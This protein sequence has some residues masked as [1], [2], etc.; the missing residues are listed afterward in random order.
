MRQLLVPTI[1]PSIN[2]STNHSINQSIIPS[3]VHTCAK[4]QSADVKHFVLTEVT[5]ISRGAHAG[6][7]MRLIRPDRW[8]ARSAVLTRVR[9]AKICTQNFTADQQLRITAVQTTIGLHATLPFC[10]GSCCHCVFERCCH[11]FM[12][13]DSSSSSSSS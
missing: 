8:D 10:Q 13:A 2:Q 1:Y 11:H 12:S 5:V 7:Q 6:Y 4:R 3:T 9:L